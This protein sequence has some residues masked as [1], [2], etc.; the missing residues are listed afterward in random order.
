MT[1]SAAV[2]CLCLLAVPSLARG[3]VDSTLAQSYFKE[4]ATLCERDGGKLWASRSA[5][6]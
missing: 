1:R 6:R 5:A 4:A 2:L 3:Q